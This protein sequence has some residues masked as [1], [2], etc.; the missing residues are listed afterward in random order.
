MWCGS[1][2]TVLPRHLRLVWCVSAL[3]GRMLTAAAIFCCCAEKPDD[4]SAFVVTPRVCV[5]NRQSCEGTSI[6]GR[7][8]NSATDCEEA[9]LQL[10]LVRNTNSTILTVNE[11]RAPK[12]C[13]LDAELRTYF[14]TA[15]TSESDFA[16]LM[17]VCSVRGKKGSNTPSS[18]SHDHET[19]TFADVCVSFALQ[20]YTRCQLPSKKPWKH[21]V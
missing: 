16:G 4:E 13:L 11:P 6:C 5:S 19:H 21:A 1:W 15:G 10:P 18:I 2:Q 14:N 9:V 12:G 3:S 7:Y 8:I 20:T 17:S